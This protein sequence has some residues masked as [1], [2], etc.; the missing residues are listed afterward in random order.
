MNQLGKTLE[1]LIVKVY[2]ELKQFHFL[3]KKHTF[4]CV[5]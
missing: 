2:S 3:I 5:T 1:F 4:V